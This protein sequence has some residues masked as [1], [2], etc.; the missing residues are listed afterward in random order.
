MLVTRDAHLG[1]IE[2]L[3]VAAWYDHNSAEYRFVAAARER[4]WKTSRV[5]KACE[6]CV[7]PQATVSLA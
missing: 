4:M 3:S 6:V 5:S 2:S 1:E 7:M